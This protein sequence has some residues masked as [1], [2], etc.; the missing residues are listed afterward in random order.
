MIAGMSMHWHKTSDELPPI[1]AE[2]LA[3]ILDD[4]MRWRLAR[5]D[6]ATWRN[7]EG[8]PIDAPHRWAVYELSVPSPFGDV[9]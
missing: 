2:V 8:T 3:D 1:D 7:L 6:G 5:F 9:S 4:P